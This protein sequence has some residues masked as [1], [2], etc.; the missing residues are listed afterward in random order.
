VQGGKQTRI[1]RRRALAGL[2]ALTAAPHLAWARQRDPLPLNSHVRV[3]ALDEMASAF[4]FEQVFRA[5]VPRLTYDVT[6]HGAE[7]EA[8]LRRNRDAFEWVDVK[9]GTPVTSADATTEILGTA[10]TMPILVG[11]SSNQGPVHPD[12]ERGMHVGASGAGATMVIATGSTVPFD[13]AIKAAPGP[14]WYQHY[15][16][17]DADGRRNVLERV[18]AAGFRA[19]V[20]TADGRSNY[21]ERDLH[22][23]HTGGR[24]RQPNR[25]RS[26]AWNPYRVNDIYP[27]PEFG[28]GYLDAV[29]PLVK[30]PLLLK[31]VLSP[32][33]AKL[34]VEHGAD[35]IIVSNHG[36]RVLDYA[37]S[38]IESLPA[39]VEAVG[40]RVPVLVDSGFRHGTDVFKALALGA[41]GVLLGRAAR[42]ALGA[43]GAPGVQ[44][45]LELLRE[46][47]ADTMKH[48]GR[49][50]VASIDR[51]CVEVRFT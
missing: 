30:V 29:R 51:S 31:G 33:D 3:P 22:D 37:P 34:A 18:Q 24:V 17:P 25:T 8:T 43:F 5:N 10:M 4:D 23:Y 16:R 46:D 7:S 11:P 47:L 26:V 44:R 13:E 15:P 14:M 1:G 48:A 42:W 21:F 40:G 12:G 50:T 45:L 32:E 28:W 38:T 35:G 41:K 39:V 6:A 20:I 9:A 36:G 49:T 27:W 2:A 19:V